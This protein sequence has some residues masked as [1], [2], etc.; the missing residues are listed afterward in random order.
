MATQ[1]SMTL[2][3]IRDMVLRLPSHERRGLAV[4]LFVSVDDEDPTDAET[5]WAEE[6]RRRV[7]EFDAGTAELIPAEQVFAEAQA[8][9]DQ[10]ARARVQTR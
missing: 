7:E 8:Q 3:E 10:V 1:T 5:A 2:D 9:V 6:I 4:D